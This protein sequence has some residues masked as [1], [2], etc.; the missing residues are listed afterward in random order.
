MLKK[1]HITA[2]DEAHAIAEAIQIFTKELKRNVQREEIQ[3]DHVSERSGLLGIGRKREYTFV[4]K[5]EAYEAES[6]IATALEALEQLTPSKL[7]GYFQLQVLP[8]GIYLRV[9]APG[10]K[11]KPVHLEAIRQMMQRKELVDVNMTLVEKTV[12]DA[13][14]EFYL[15]AE[16]KPELDRGAR[17][18]VK[19]SPDKLNAY[20]TYAPPLGAGRPT[21]LQ[22]I[23][24]VN[25]QG[26]RYGIDEKRLKEAIQ[27]NLHQEFHLAAGQPPE[28]GIP[29]ELRYHF[30]LARDHK[31]VKEREDGS[32]DYL[33]L[34][35]VCSVHRGDLLV[36]KQPAT[37]GIPGRAVTGEAIKSIP[38]KDIRLPRGKNVA[39][40]PDE[41]SLFAM[42]DG[43]AFLDEGKVSVLP[44]YFINGDVDLETGNIQFVG[45]VVVKGNVQEGFS[46]KADG[47]VEI[48]GNVG[49]AVIE[50]GGSVVV[51]KGFQGKQKGLIRANGDVHCSFI[52]NAAVFTRGSLQVNGAVMHSEI[53]A[54][55][56]VV[57]EGRGLIVGGT[58]KAGNDVTA[59]TIG[60][61]LATPTEV[62]AGVDPEIRQQLDHVNTELDSVVENLDKVEKGLEQLHK[63]QRQ[64]GDKLPPDKIALIQQFGRTAQHL[65]EQQV[66]L[67]E[68]KEVLTQQLRDQKNGRVRVSDR[69]YPGV[70]IFI[71]QAGYRVKDSLARTA[72][73][74]D[75]GEVR[76]TPL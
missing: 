68:Q 75:E 31:R 33:N 8:T 62:M 30:E 56:D 7:D 35:L 59:K 38:G 17:F 25:A 48:N 19:I 55:V 43:Q 67:V 26:V 5:D 11:G 29:A 6:Q 65:Q 9:V 57:V 44:V 49:A 73:V 4:L 54:K 52:E 16:R 36:T 13:D 40:S 60:S 20:C 70:K 12:Q 15:I 74:Y 50:A 18:E 66:N 3:L 76:T 37:A 63:L 10:E 22:A 34:D 1:I 27:E 61:H 53:V 39:V 21:L 2:K 47:D 45:N 46:I 72:F 51:R 69:V 71:G 64:F 24:A 14:G 42:L 41:M 32:V 28:H 23:E 58:V